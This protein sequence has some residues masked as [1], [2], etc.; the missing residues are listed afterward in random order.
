MSLLNPKNLF[1]D[2]Y[3][4]NW[5]DNNELLDIYNKYPSNHFEKVSLKQIADRVK[6]EDSIWTT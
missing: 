1:N 2:L 4:Y 5:K 6:L 3:G